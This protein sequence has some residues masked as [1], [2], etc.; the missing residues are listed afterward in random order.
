MAKIVKIHN[1]DI[2]YLNSEEIKN[3]QN[4]IFKDEI[5][6]VKLSGKPRIIDIGGHLGLATIYFKWRYPDAKISVYE[7]NPL[8]FEYLNR[9][10]VNNGFDDIES[11][12]LGVSKSGGKQKLYI[13]SSTDMFFSTASMTSN[14]YNEREIDIETV[15]LSEI[16]KKKKGGV[17]DL[18]KIDIEGME[19]SVLEE[20]KDYLK[21]IKN[22]II[23]VH[24]NLGVKL[25]K[26]VKLLSP[27]FDIEGIDG[28]E[29][30]LKIIKAKAK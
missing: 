15:K 24:L 21:N 9:N 11:F 28:S 29:P 7:P 5:Y 2:E 6:S 30:Y 18:L 1:F 10:L 20:S 8:I 19:Y 16:V 17:I 27:D 12:N 23:E 25:E 4:E 26:I 13:D 3:L 14:L 22:I